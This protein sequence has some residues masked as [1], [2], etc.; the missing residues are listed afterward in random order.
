MTPAAAAVVECGRSEGRTFPGASAKRHKA[1]GNLCICAE[2]PAGKSETGGVGGMGAVVGLV[3]V[4]A[5]F[6]E[7]LSLIII[8]NMARRRRRSAVG[9]FIFTLIFGWLTALVLWPMG[10]K[11]LKKCQ[12]CGQMVPREATRC[13]H[14]QSDLSAG[15]GVTA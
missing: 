9:W 8:V 14:C 15:A 3:V 10:S 5:L 11:G 2:S 6:W 7:V 4:W 13:A 1:A 12:R